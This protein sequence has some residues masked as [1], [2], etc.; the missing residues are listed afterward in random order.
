MRESQPVL[1]KTDSVGANPVLFSDELPSDPDVSPG[2][3]F[4]AWFMGLLPIE[5]HL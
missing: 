3:R 5:K 2:R 1:D 4:S